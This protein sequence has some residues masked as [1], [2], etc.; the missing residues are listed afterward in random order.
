VQQAPSAESALRPAWTKVVFSVIVSLVL[1][2][3]L[4]LL[5]AGL[6]RLG[7]RS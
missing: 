4:A 7:A 5:T 6:A 2:L 3:G 1:V